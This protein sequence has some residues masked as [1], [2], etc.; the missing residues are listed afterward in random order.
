MSEG[1][2]VPIVG[3]EG[4]W[5]FYFIIDLIGIVLVSVFI[6]TPK[7][8]HNIKIPKTKDFS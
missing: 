6:L 1:S 7:Q 4:Q 8:I 3:S 2:I 5:F